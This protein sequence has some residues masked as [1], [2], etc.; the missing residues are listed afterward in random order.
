MTLTQEL[1]KHEEDGNVDKGYI[2][3][4]KKKKRKKKRY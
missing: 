3:Y 1:D 2:M 4:N